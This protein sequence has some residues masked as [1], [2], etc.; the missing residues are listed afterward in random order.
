[1][2]SLL[3]AGII[4]LFLSHSANA[5]VDMRTANF[6]DVWN[7]LTARG[8]GYDLRYQRSFNSRTIYSGFNGFGWC[9]DYETSLEVNAEG[10]LRI[11][12]CGGGLQVTYTQKHFDQKSI[13]KTV[14]TIIAE[15]K[16]RNPSRT[17][18]YLRGLTVEMTENKYLREEF[19]RQLKLKGKV[20]KGKHYLANNRENDYIVLKG[21]EYIR[22]VPDGTFQRFKP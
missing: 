5:I 3:F 8:T 13:K 20:V 7:D 9:S 18:K 11:T 15:V 12:E 6:G 14:N 17:A 21:K 22:Y 4:T 1:M 19:A 2:K 10:N 16:K